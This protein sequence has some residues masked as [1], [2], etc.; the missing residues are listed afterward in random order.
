LTSLDTRSD[1]AIAGAATDVTHQTP[2]KL[3]KYAEISNSQRKLMRRKTR[4]KM[5]LKEGLKL[6]R[7]VNLNRSMEFT[8]KNSI[9]TQ[10]NLQ[11]RSLVPSRF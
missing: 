7:P 10:E 9:G 1:H 8:R 2:P 11:V 4:E 3:A 5:L 6:G